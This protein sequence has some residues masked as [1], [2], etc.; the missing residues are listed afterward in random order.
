[1]TP[2]KTIKI[3]HKSHCAD[4]LKKNNKSK[5]PT[6]KGYAR[7]VREN[8]TETEQNLANDWFK[9]KAGACDKPKTRK[10]PPPGGGFCKSRK[11]GRGSKPKLKKYAPRR[12]RKKSNYYV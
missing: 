4:L 3:M 8:G 11:K 2:G 12:S 1:M 5:V 7:D 6:L 10:V 9:N